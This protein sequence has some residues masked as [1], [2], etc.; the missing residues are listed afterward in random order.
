LSQNRPDP[1][2]PPQPAAKPAPQ[3]LH[4]LTPALAE[5]LWLSGAFQQLRL[6]DSDLL[7]QHDAHYIGAYLAQ[8]VPDGKM[9]E[10]AR[11]MW[12]RSQSMKQPPAEWLGRF[13][14]GWVE[15]WAPG[16]SSLLPLR[17]QAVSETVFANYQTLV[18]PRQRKKDT[19][20]S[21]KLD[22]QLVTCLN[23]VAQKLSPSSGR[24]VNEKIANALRAHI[25]PE[26]VQRDFL[27]TVTSAGQARTG[28]AR[29]RPE[30]P[31]R[32]NK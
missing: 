19:A 27:E 30:P 29:R 14:A 6:P 1:K 3:N 22:L 21:D 15:T 13:Y 16:A 26:H 20:G 8:W 31:G 12:T 5:S 11:H 25:R 17:A 7:E 4:H 24:L 28:A 32:D 23:A 9:P 10:I 2:P 18:A